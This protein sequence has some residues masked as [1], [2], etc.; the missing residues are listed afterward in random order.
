MEEISRENKVL[1]IQLQKIF[2]P[3]VNLI[4]FDKFCTTTKKV[5]LIFDDMCQLHT[6]T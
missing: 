4:R 6:V 2:H 5:Q 3:N 1:R